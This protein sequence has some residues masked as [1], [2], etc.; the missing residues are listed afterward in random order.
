MSEWIKFTQN[1]ITSTWDQTCDTPV[2][3]TGRCSALWQ[4]EVVCVREVQ[5]HLRR[6]SDI[7]GAT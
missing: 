4:I 6:S 3:L 2:L 1:F 5:Q 7:P